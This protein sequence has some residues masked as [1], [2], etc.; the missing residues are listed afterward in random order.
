MRCA[1][2]FTYACVAMLRKTENIALELAQPLTRM[3]RFLT[4]SIVLWEN[5]GLGERDFDLNSCSELVLVD[6]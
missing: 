3:L 1:I 2:Y 6:G 4:N 5:N